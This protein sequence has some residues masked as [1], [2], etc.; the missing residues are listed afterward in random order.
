MTPFM[1]TPKVRTCKFSNITRFLHTLFLFKHLNITM[2]PSSRHIHRKVSTTGVNPPLICLL[3]GMKIPGAPYHGIANSDKNTDLLK[4]SQC[5]DSWKPDP[6][7]VMV[8]S[9]EV[10][11]AY[12][13]N[14]PRLWSRLCRASEFSI[15]ILREKPAQTL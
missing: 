15:G 3:C 12:I 10:E 5:K 14:Y 7:H 9:H 2:A 11:E 13:S 4:D 6:K 1:N 8:P